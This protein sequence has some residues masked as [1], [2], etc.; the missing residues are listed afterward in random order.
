MIFSLVPKNTSATERD[1]RTTSTV[2]RDIKVL[3]LSKKAKPA[4]AKDEWEH[5]ESL[6]N[7]DLNRFTHCLILG[8]FKIDFNQFKNTHF[9]YGS[10]QE[11][12]TFKKMHNP[13]VTVF[14]TKGLKEFEKVLTISFL[15]I[16]ENEET[17]AKPLCGRHV[18]DSEYTQP[19]EHE[20]EEALRQGLSTFKTHSG[21]IF[22]ER[23]RTL[24]KQDYCTIRTLSALEFDGT[25]FLRSTL[26]GMHLSQDE[27]INGR[28]VITPNQ[29]YT[30]FIERHEIWKKS[31]LVQDPKETFPK[32]LKIDVSSDGDNFEVF[33]PVHLMGQ[34]RGSHIVIKY[35]KGRSL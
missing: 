18:H 23:V 21:R 4:N 25:E 8:D 35:Y 9:F 28:D 16:L 20:R 5:A 15:K 11:P 12:A 19:Q 22:F 30:G 10:N 27:S 29:I 3:I 33:C 14:W 34:A 6:E 2:S 7:L 1:K 31:R 24:S 17:P 32:N 26:E 13:N